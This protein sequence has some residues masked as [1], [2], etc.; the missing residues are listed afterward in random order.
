MIEQWI[1]DVVAGQKT[2]ASVLRLMDLTGKSTIANDYSS[3]MTD[4]V[5]GYVEHDDKQVNI[6][7]KPIFY[8]LATY[9][10]R[11]ILENKFSEHLGHMPALGKYIDTVYQ[12]AQRFPEL[13]KAMV[14][15]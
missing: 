11:V 13:A 7:D 8:K 14:T 15:P 1:K 5:F 4:E 9:C 2:I 10:D 12:A 3:A 6:A